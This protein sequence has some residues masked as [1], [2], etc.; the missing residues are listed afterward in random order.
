M[1]CHFRLSF[2]ALDLT[3][4]CQRQVY[5]VDGTLSIPL[6]GDSRGLA[7]WLRRGV[8]RRGRGAGCA[9]GRRAL[10]LSLPHIWPPLFALWG[11]LWY[12]GPEKGEGQTGNHPSGPG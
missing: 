4:H 9:G 12:N 11:G 1:G 5:H 10:G 6:S 2:L 7:R 3:V 8:A